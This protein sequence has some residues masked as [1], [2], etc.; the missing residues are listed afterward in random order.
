M[1]SKMAPRPLG[2]IISEIT[3][4]AEND[5]K[6]IYEL[7]LFAIDEIFSKPK[8]DILKSLVYIKSK[9]L[10]QIREKLFLDCVKK[11]S[12][13]GQKEPLL[14]IINAGDLSS[15]ALPGDLLSCL[16][17]RYKPNYEDIYIIGM[18]FV[19]N[20]LH[21]DFAKIICV[22]SKRKSFAA[23]D[24]SSSAEPSPIETKA[25]PTTGSSVSKGQQLPEQ[26][27]QQQQQQQKQQQQQQQKQQQPQ[28]QQQFLS[29][30]VVIKMLD[31]YTEIIDRLEGLK[32]ENKEQ[33]DSIQLLCTKV[34]KQ[35]M[36][37]TNLKK[38]HELLKTQITNSRAK[39]DV[40]GVISNE[41]SALEQKQS[42]HRADNIKSIVANNHLQKQQNLQKQQKQQQQQQQ[43]QNEKR[44]SQDRGAFDDLLN[45][46]G[47]EPKSPKNKWGKANSNS[48]RLDTNSKSRGL[49]SAGGAIPRRQLTNTNSRS[50]PTVPSPIFGRKNSNKAKLAGV[51]AVKTYSLFI[52]G[53]KLDIDEDALNN[54]IIEEFGIEPVNI[55]IN[56]SNK[57]NRSFKVDIK[58]ED[59]DGLLIPEKW[60]NNIIIKPF[61]IRRRVTPYNQEERRQQFLLNEAETGAKQNTVNVLMDQYDIFSDLDTANPW[62]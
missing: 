11:L 60:E 22:T 19:E 38:E 30:E 51:R 37:Y 55:S 48:N 35:H 16:R 39:N 40:S 47:Y 56:K 53:I 4:V 31:S 57:Y 14:N 54:H 24:A 46:L 5:G 26:Q 50:S 25:T 13:E 1:A 6:D 45:S 2:V 42:L 7:F 49:A 17:R 34:D 18:S 8:D 33:K 27:Q 62:L 15:S 10:I 32:K 9:D 43:Q 3:S 58:E 41:M 28:Q 36:E 52:G 12:A 44:Q 20:K 21:K 61:K 23:V 29:Q 59:K